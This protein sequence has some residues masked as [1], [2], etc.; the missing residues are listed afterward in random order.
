M[1][2]TSPSR[3]RASSRRDGMDTEDGLTPTSSLRW[4]GSPMSGRSCTCADRPDSWKRQRARSWHSAM[5]RVES[6][7]NASEAPAVKENGM[8]RLDGNAVAGVMV[9]VFGEEMTNATGNCAGCGKSVRLGEAMVYLPAPGIV[10]RCPHCD[11]TLMVVVHR[12]DTACVDL[13]G[14][15][16]FNRPPDQ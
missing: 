13:T 10:A 7:L 14:M 5:S 2:W 15:T 6:A 12:R 1:A 16:T 9:D 4:L 11:N 3:S 8:S